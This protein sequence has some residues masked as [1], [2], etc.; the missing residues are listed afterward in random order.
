MEC[1]VSPK[2]ARLSTLKLLVQLRLQ[3]SIESSN[4]EWS[5]LLKNYHYQLGG[6]NTESIPMFYKQDIRI[7]DLQP[8]RIDVHRRLC[9]NNWIE[10]L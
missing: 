2:L 8:F 5:N 4:N 7:E 1:I 9:K 6:I 10:I 3:I